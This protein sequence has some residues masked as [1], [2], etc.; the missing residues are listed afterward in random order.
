MLTGYYIFT[1]KTDLFFVI[2]NKRTTYKTLQTI[3]DAI[4]KHLGIET[5]PETIKNRLFKAT[6]IH[7]LLATGHEVID[8][9]GNGF[10]Y[11]AYKPNNKEWSKT[12]QVYYIQDG[13][14]QEYSNETIKTGSI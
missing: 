12:T 14:V 13:T 2:D 6:F 3:S 1:P 9:K 11:G 5:T 8:I 4:N 10:S 7:R